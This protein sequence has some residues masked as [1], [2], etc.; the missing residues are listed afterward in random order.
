MSI[1]SLQFLLTYYSL[2]H[3]YVTHNLFVQHGGAGDQKSTGLGFTKILHKIAAISKQV[4][5]GLYLIKRVATV[6]HRLAHLEQTHVQASKK[7]LDQEKH[8]LKVPYKE[9]CC[10]LFLKI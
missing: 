4:E 6:I 9:K 8:K 1:K 7:A 3:L 5:G 2:L 10:S